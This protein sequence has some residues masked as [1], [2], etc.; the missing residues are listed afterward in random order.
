M[1]IDG[2]PVGMSMQIPFGRSLSGVDEE[3]KDLKEPVLELD[4]RRKVSSGD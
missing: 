3:D 1:I 4:D 2:A